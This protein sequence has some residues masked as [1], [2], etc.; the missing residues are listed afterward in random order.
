MPVY[1]CAIALLGRAVL[2]LFFEERVRF[3]RLRKKQDAGRIAIKPMHDARARYDLALRTGPWL[4]H[5]AQRRVVLEHPRGH[6]WFFGA[7][8]RM[9]DESRGLI[10]DEHVRIFVKDRYVH[11]VRNNAHITV[12]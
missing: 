12:W 4:T 11:P 1:E 2:E 8:V 3:L 10:Y 9:D 7:S 5:A 6:G